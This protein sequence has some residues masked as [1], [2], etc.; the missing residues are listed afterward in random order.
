LKKYLIE[1]F[2]KAAKKLSYLTE[3]D[4][5]FDTPKSNEHGDLS[6]N[7]AMMLSK[8]LKKNPKQIAE[9]IISNLDYE[10]DVI[11]KV[12]IAGPGFINFF[13]TANYKTQVVTQILK[14]KSNFGRSNKHNGQKANVEFVSANP[15]GPLT[16]GHGRNAV[17]GDSVANM[18]ETIGYTVEREYYFNNAGRQMRVLGDSVK[19]RYFELLGQKVDFPEDYYQGEYIKD[20][21]LKFHDEYGD[22]LTDEDPEGK[23]KEKAEEEIF[24][25]IKNTL[26]RLNIT[27]DTF[28]NENSLYQDGKIDE[29]LSVFEEK[30]L[31]YKKDDAIWLKFSELGVAEDKVIVKATG[32]PTYRLPDIA[33]HKIKFDRNYDL[34]VDVFGSDHIASY[35]DVLAGLK[36]VNKDTDKV[37][38]LIYQ[39]VTLLEDGEVIKMSTRKANYVTLDQLIDDVGS[40]VVRYFFNMRNI[41]SH[42]NFDLTL[43]KKQ[44]DENPVFYLQYAHARIC[45]IIRTVAEEKIKS[46]VKN[47]ELLIKEEEQQLINK[48]NEYEEVVLIAAENFEPHRICTYLTELATAFHKFYTFCR[49]LGSEKKLAEARLALA[50]ATKTV[51]Q[52]GLGILG[53]T[54]PERM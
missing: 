20:I 32:E 45:S 25:D 10:E 37:K 42:M 39:F 7:A 8:R 9:E 47:M 24:N 22:K 33:Y 6:C 15:T 34:M 12:E 18:L 17:I 1:L 23:F 29:L 28:F 52:N 41:S 38:V 13:F 19:L 43:A 54:A 14:E 49:I 30:G 50:Q 26:S 46:S 4:H 53:V 40:D 5:S 27:F 48:L 35:P 21:E 16:V 2:N 44:S 3:I 11:E 51:L 31:S 36:A